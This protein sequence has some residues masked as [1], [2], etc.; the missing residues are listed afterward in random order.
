MN[1][2]P[3]TPRNIVS[4]LY[5]DIPQCKTRSLQEIYE[6]DCFV[7]MVSEPVTYGDAMLQEK[8]IFPMKEEISAIER[9]NT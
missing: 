2:V 4:D 6:I 5:S 7:L 3:K 1:K 8:W 9:N